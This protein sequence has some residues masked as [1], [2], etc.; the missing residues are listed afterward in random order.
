MRRGEGWVGTGRGGGLKPEK[1]GGEPRRTKTEGL[2]GVHGG[3]C[4][5][6]WLGEIGWREGG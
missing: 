5:L 1:E 3:S 2:R 4:W 6:G